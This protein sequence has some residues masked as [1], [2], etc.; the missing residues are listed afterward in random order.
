MGH[1]DRERILGDAIEDLAGGHPVIVPTE[2]VYTVLV[3]AERA[4]TLQVPDGGAP[5]W[6]ARC[7]ED[8]LVV[9]GPGRRVHRRLVRRLAPGP[10]E[11]GVEGPVGDG[12][13]LREQVSP[14]RADL[15]VRIP[16]HPAAQM[17]ITGA[18]ERSGDRIVGVT[19]SGWA[20]PH[21]VPEDPGDEALAVLEDGKTRLGRPPTLVS[22]RA[23]GRFWVPRE[24]AIEERFVL[25]QLERT[26]LFVCT[27]NTCRSPMAE[28]IARDA[29][30]VSEDGFVTRVRSAG[31]AAASG[32]PMSPEAVE[33]LRRLGV[34]PGEHRSSTLT[35]QMIADA[36][37][38]FAMTRSHHRAIL[39]IDPSASGKVHL[40][41]PSG[42]DV[43]DPFGGTLEMYE[44]T[45]RRLRE[46]VVWRIKEVEP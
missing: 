27:G 17:L 23:D 44:R 1:A 29:L 10:V 4:S 40:L 35:R 5:A 26:L 43:A 3:R 19:V 46:L 22:L 34:E 20:T 38:I 28:A 7:V 8:V 31:V 41:D 6:H 14:D 21:E 32:S 16:D 25:K 11:F 12:A 24:G 15:L 36:E 13:A 30:G 39:S 33:A 37:E 42:E 18:E 9:I 45:A 2:C